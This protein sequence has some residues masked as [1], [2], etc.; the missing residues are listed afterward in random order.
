MDHKYSFW[1]VKKIEYFY[2]LAQIQLIDVCQGTQLS[3]NTHTKLQQKLSNKT[4]TK[5]IYTQTR[6][7]WN[8]LVF[9]DLIMN[10][11]DNP[12]QNNNRI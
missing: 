12:K 2:T 1:N 6:M 11:F 7:L 5:P 9:F 8:Y 10:V 3:K 4:Y